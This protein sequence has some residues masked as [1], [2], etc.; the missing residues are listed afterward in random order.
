MNKI[1]PEV[2]SVTEQNS[3]QFSTERK[4]YVELELR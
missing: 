3:I 1:Q 2:S 4:Y